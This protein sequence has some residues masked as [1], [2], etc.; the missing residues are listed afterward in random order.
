MRKKAEAVERLSYLFYFIF[1]DLT[2]EG[3]FA[4]IEEFCG[5]FLFAS[6]LGEGFDDAISIEVFDIVFDE[7][8]VELAIAFVGIDIIQDIGGPDGFIIE[9]KDAF[10]DVFEF[11]DISRERIFGES[12]IE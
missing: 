10:D 9:D 4:H 8:S 6:G 7:V 5:G 12:A 11:A 3:G 1:F 2:G